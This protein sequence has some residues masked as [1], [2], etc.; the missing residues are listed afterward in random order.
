MDRIWYVQVMAAALMVVGSVPG[1]AQEVSIST[2]IPQSTD[3]EAAQRGA[4]YLV[5]PEVEYPPMARRLGMEA[6]ITGGVWVD[7]QGVPRKSRIIR[8]EPAH[9]DLFDESVQK[10]MMK[11]RYKPQLVGGKAQ[12]GWYCVPLIFKLEEQPGNVLPRVVQQAVPVYPRE[13]TEQGIEGW[14]AV[15]VPLDEEGRPDKSRL[16]ILNRFPLKFTSFDA[17]AQDAVM[18]SRFEPGRS[19]GRAA[20][21]WIV[22]RIDFNLPTE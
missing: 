14:V 11:A 19:R 15:A 16:V 8:R 12:G 13:G 3:A 6:K 1:I 7:A 18:A 2:D 20:P 22:V 21:G 10:F 4:V 5:R 17:K 9:L